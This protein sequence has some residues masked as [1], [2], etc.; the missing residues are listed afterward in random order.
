MTS[1]RGVEQRPAGVAGIDGRVG[2]DGVFNGRAVGVA[3]GADGA[4]D[5]AGHGAAEAEGIADGID[6]LADVELRGVGQ[7]D[8]L[9][10]GRVDLQQRQVVH[11]VGADDL[12]LIAALVAEHDFDAAVG[13]L[14]DVEVGEDVAGFVEDESRAL[15]LLRHGPIEEV[16]DQRGGGD[17]DHRRQHFLVD[18]DVVLLFGVVGGRG[19]GLS[20]FERRAGAVACRMSVGRSAEKRSGKMGGDEPES[21]HQQQNDQENPA[22]SHDSLDLEN[23][24]D[25]DTAAAS[26][27][28]LDWKARPPT[29]L[30]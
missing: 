22:Q 13:A 7:R 19:V 5:A 2:L 1:P 25:T 15:A 29:L 14:D 17:V 28:F 20:E 6:L 27:E 8:G 26:A 30:F 12:R 24:P 16:E 23:L 21:A 9:Q 10:I 4:D 11:L 18:G 3:D